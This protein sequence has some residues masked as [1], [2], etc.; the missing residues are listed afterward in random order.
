MSKLFFI[1]G[2]VILVLLLL[3]MVRLGTFSGFE[4]FTGGESATPAGSFTLYYADWCPHCKTVKPLFEKFASNG[5]FTVNGKNVELKLVEESDK[6]A[7]AGKE[8]KGFPTFLFQSAQGDTV[9]Y[10][11]PRTEE[12]WKKFLA[13]TV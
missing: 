6:A 10:S 11:G 9:E 2:G 7:M 1:V 12:A 8:V 5:V 13:E 3:S 4:G